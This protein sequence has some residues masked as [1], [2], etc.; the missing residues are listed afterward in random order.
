VSFTRFV[1]REE[2][3]TSRRELNEKPVSS[4]KTPAE[5]KDAFDASAAAWENCRSMTSD[6]ADEIRT[7]MNKL[8]ELHRVTSDA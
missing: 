1:S 5:I 7:R 3:L 2:P 8:K 6:R 4:F